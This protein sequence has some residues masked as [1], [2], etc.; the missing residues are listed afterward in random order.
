LLFT[1]N[2]VR[3]N[4]YGI[5]G[6]DRAPGNE[7]IAAFFPTSEIAGNAIAEGPAGR[8]PRRNYFP[9][10]SE[11]RSQ[12]IDYARGDYRLKP[13]SS[14]TGAGTDG[15]ALGADLSALP[16]AP[17]SSAET[18]PPRRPINFVIDPPV[19]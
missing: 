16:R 3:H 4:A 7:T 14:W 6:R 18:S 5:I 10:T 1:N 19:L 13:T 9:S 15:A 17:E 2:V 12:F 11:F 8:Y